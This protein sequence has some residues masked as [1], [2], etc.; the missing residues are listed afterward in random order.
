MGARA[1]TCRE[2]TSCGRREGGLI[3]VEKALLS[4]IL[5]DAEIRPVIEAK[6]TAEFFEDDTYAAL[7]AW[8]VDH[9]GRYQKVPGVKTLRA[10]Y[11]NFKPIITDEPLAFYIE[12]MM[13]AR[14]YTIIHDT[15]GLAAK[16]VKDGEVP[17]ATAVLT[18][19]LGLLH[20]EV[21]AIS[22]ADITA[23]VPERLERYQSYKNL[24]GGLRGMP[25][26]FPALDDATLGLQAEQLVTLIGLPK[27]GKS[28]TVL[29]TAMAVQD[30]GKR[31]LFIGFEMSNVEQQARYD[32]WRGKVNYRRLMSGKL[33]ELEERRLTK[34]LHGVESMTPLIFAEDIS[35]TTTVSGVAA[36]VDQHKPDLLIVD[37]V[38]L[39]EA[40]I[41]NVIPGS[42]QAL[43]SITRGLKRLAQRMKIPVLATTQVLPSK[44]S[45]RR[46]LTLDSIGYTSSFAQDSDVIIGV[47]S[48][49]DE[50]LKKVKIVAAR[51]SRGRE[52]LVV[53]DWDNASFMEL[54]E[55]GEEEWAGADA[56]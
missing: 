42:P 43:T 6:I 34:A 46:G 51:N 48:T 28:T 56:V 9:Y 10:N 45:E 36:K 23:N 18:E 16:H 24:S 5:V 25:T 1:C 7:W 33:S 26:G 14:K 44:Y 30:I 54:D 29:V 40:E 38:Y 41:P 15:V 49:E 2:A 35:A 21:S 53:W 4:K 11:P 8:M 20:R 31:A 55:V 17:E 50:A 39:M 37:G 19:G 12:Q 52:V 3:D 27:A 22:D 13:Q 32:A 47:E